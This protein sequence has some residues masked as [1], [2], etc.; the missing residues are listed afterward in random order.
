MV[1]DHTTYVLCANISNNLV[2]VNNISVRY[3]G[4]DISPTKK[5]RIIGVMVI[6]TTLKVIYLHTNSIIHYICIFP[7]F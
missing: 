3:D 1:C 2:D 4:A 5:D 6:E 7:K